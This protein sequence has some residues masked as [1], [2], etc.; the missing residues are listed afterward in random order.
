[1]STLNQLVTFLKELK[2]NNSKAWFDPNRDRYKNLDSEMHKLISRIL[3]E[4]AQFDTSLGFVNPKDCTYRI[5]RDVRFSNDKSPYKTWYGIVFSSGDAKNGCLPGYY[6]HIDADGSCMIG[7]GWYVP[8]SKMLFDLRTKISENPEKLRKILSAKE[9]KSYFN[10]LEGEQLK[11]NP[12]GFSKED[13]A[14]DL[15][16]FKNFTSFKRVDVS[17]MEDTD[18]VSNMVNTFAVIQPLVQYMKETK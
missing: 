13:P 16:R 8:D 1:M 14:I 9:F 10:G 17:Q 15:L 18:F 6:A 3:S 2:A 7:G 11:T 5:N 4:S 12:K